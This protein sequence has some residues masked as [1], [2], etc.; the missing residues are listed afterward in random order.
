MG[1]RL[2]HRHEVL[3]ASDAATVF[4]RARSGAGNASWMLVAG[5]LREDLLKGQFV[6]PTVAE[7]VVV[8]SDDTRTGKVVGDGDFPT[9]QY[10]LVAL[11]SVVIRDANLQN[12]AR[13][14]L[15]HAEQV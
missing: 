2:N 1:G 7:I 13:D 9:R 4:G 14:R 10:G 12:L 15:G 8:L 11:E 3:I 5:L 6:F